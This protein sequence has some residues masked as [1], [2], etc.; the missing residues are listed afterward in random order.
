MSQSGAICR[1]ARSQSG[2]RFHRVVEIA[3]GCWLMAC[4]G[5][6]DG[7][8]AADATGEDTVPELSVLQDRVDG[9]VRELDAQ[10][11]L[12]GTLLVARGDRI[13][14]ERAFGSANF[15]LNT[16]NTTATRY[17]VASVTKLLTALLAARLIERGELG[18]GDPIS[19]YLPDFPRGDAIPVESLL[20]HRSGI[21]HRVTADTDVSETRTAADMVDLAREAELLFEPGSDRAYSSAG[22]SVLARVL[23]IAGGGTYG[24]LLQRE[25]LRPA[26]ALHTVSDDGATLVPGRAQD[27]LV[28]A[29]GPI[30][31][32][33]AD[34]SFLV[35][36]GSVFS[37]PRDLWQVVRALEAGVYGGLA[38][39][40]LFEDG[41]LHWNGE[42]FG[43]RAFV[44]Y[45]AGGAAV[46]FAGNV[47]NGAPGLL[48]R[49]AF[50]IASGEEVAPPEVPDWEPVLLD[51]GRRDAISGVYQFSAGD[52]DS[53]ETLRFA[54]D[55][56]YA[57][58]GSWV[59]VPVAD[60]AFF[61][62]TDYARLRVVSS[63][64]EGVTGL[65]WHLGEDSFYLPRVRA[66]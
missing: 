38:R 34:V 16:P 37:T 10:A 11:V 9:Y 42:T 28:G 57:S 6:L 26:D 35:G 54:P 18:P 1:T 32:R 14:Y 31:T 4:P 61:G 8:E 63:G 41:E 27:Y 36:A 56:S 51:P 39:S 12:S 30:P 60:D 48:R 2:F 23:E 33:P 25:V 59:L 66:R 55:G 19:D 58:L 24:E 43:Y 15:E 22:Y 40:E 49:A 29:R 52:P 44:D 47:R 65:E 53:E 21:P 62:T 64:G 3:I 50:A 20:R 7:Q 17:G 5:V 13:V 45:R 46:I